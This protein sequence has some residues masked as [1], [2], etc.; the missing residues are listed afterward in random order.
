[1]C[2]RWRL[3]LVSLL[4]SLRLENLLRFLETKSLSLRVGA[5]CVCWGTPSTVSQIVSNCA[6][7]FMSCLHRASRSARSESSGP[8]QLFPKYVHSLGHDPCLPDPKEYVT[9]FQ[10]SLQ[11]DNS[12]DFPFKLFGRRI[13]YPQLL[14]VILAIMIFNNC[15]WLFSTNT[16]EEAVHTKLL[17]PSQVK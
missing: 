3:S 17:A 4:V 11:T 5:V 7:I 15:L 2:G 6:L 9:A 12:P 1:M 14:S 8:S 10:T 13:I 16:W